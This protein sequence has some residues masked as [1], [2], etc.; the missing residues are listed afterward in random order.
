MLKELSR[1]GRE[2][3]TYR[4]RPCLFF[5]SSFMKR[6]DWISVRQLLK[7]CEGDALDVVVHSPG[8][9]P[10]AAYLI[11]RELGRRFAK[12][13]VFVP[14]Y[15]KSAATLLSLVGDEIVLTSLGEL[16]PIDLQVQEP[17]PGELADF[18][19]CL[20]RFKALEQLQRHALET[21]NSVVSIGLAQGM[22]LMDAC[23][24]GSDMTGKLMAPLYAQLSPERIG[25]SARHLEAAEQYAERLLR[26]YRL[27]IADDDRTS[28]IRMLGRGYPSHAFIVDLEELVDLGLTARLT[29]GEEERLLLSALP[30]MGGDL[31]RVYQTSSGPEN[32]TEATTRAASRPRAMPGPQ[33]ASGRPGVSSEPNGSDHQ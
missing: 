2:L 33:R 20:Q 9:D 21:F 19:S 4:Q 23:Q 1:I 11:A 10:E 27:E 25:Q 6:D 32:R 3:T 31:I 15:A 29:D 22:S 7:D 30:H 13:T 8:G 5:A 28:I 18:T 26:R 16:G 14:F 12:R 17:R 24:V